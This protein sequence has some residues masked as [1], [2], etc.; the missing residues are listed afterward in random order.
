MSAL[1]Y[2]GI[3]FARVDSLPFDLSD[4]LY[5]CFM[6]SLISLSSLHFLKKIVFGVS[7]AEWGSSV[8]GSA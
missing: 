4:F 2:S 8:V 1:R 3:K 6:S 5:E 7:K